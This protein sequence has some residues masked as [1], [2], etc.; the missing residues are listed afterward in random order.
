MAVSKG[1]KLARLLA[2]VGGVDENGKRVAG[3]PNYRNSNGWG[4]DSGIPN[5]H[6]CGEPRANRPKGLV[7]SL[8]GCGLPIDDEALAGQASFC[9]LGLWEGLKPIDEEKRRSEL[10]RNWP[11]KEPKG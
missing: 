6:H 7:D 5:W 4:N 11:A 8:P 9:P 3:C 1:V 10:R 2:C